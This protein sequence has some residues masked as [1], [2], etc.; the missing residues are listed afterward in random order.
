MRAYEE[1]V[2]LATEL[3]SEYCYATLGKVTGLATNSILNF[4]NNTI[5]Q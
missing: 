5:V 2:R 1:E 3:L 4:N